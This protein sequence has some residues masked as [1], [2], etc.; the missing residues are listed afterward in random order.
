MTI[1]YPRQVTQVPAQLWMTK[2]QTELQLISITRRA[3]QQLPR[4]QFWEGFRSVFSCGPFG[5]GPLGDRVCFRIQNCKEEWSIGGAVSPRQNFNDISKKYRLSFN[6]IQAL[7]SSKH[8][9]WTRVKF[10]STY[11][12]LN[13]ERTKTLY[14][15]SLCDSSL[16][17][18]ISWCYGW[19]VGVSLELMWTI[20]FLV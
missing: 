13:S 19:L 2:W 15:P 3:S 12:A 4:A 16:Q 9:S 10:V 6:K 1:L 11:S 20:M 8:S 14:K 5:L 7:C 18:V 17:C